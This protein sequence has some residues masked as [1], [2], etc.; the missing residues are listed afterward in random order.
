MSAVKSCPH[1]GCTGTLTPTGYCLA[2]GERVDPHTGL[3]SDAAVR[4]ASDTGPG[5]RPGAGSG[6]ESG[7][8]SGSGSGSESGSESGAA[9]GFDSGT[10]SAPRSGSGSQERESS[11]HWIVE[12]GYTTGPPPRPARIDLPPEHPDPTVLPEITLLDRADSGG[13]G[14]DA[15][16]ALPLPPGTLLAGQY[17]L[18]RPL[19]YG[20]MGEVCLAHDTKVGDRAVAVK[21]LHAELAAD[22]YSLLEGERKELVELNHDG[23]IRVFNYGHH[24][25]V[26]DFLVLQY[27]DGLN[28]EEV[29]ARAHEHP[30]EFGGRR[31]LEFVL[32]Y[33]VRIL[34]ALAYLHAPERGKVYGDLKPPNVMHDGS[35]TKLVDV[36]SVRRA[37]V[38][39][40]T[41]GLYR[42]PSVGEHG[43]SAP[44]DDLF[45][46]GE[47]LRTLCG[48]GATRHDLADLSALDPLN[49]AVADHRGLGLVSLARVLRRATRTARAGRFA[50]ARE[51]DEQLRGVFRELRSLRTG[52]ET[53]EPSPLFLQSAYA[54]DGGLGAAPEVSRWA[55]PPS[56]P[57]HLAP[58]PPEVARRLPV[59]R[60]DPDDDHHGEL[61]RLSDDDPEALLQHTADWRDSPEVHLLRCRLR[62]RAAP[63][64]DG[65][66]LTEAET[67]LAL[68]E[69]AIGPAR[70]PYDWRLDWHRGL[71]ALAR[72]RVAQARGHFDRV[73]GAIPGEYAP[74]LALG[75]CAERLD[76]R[77]EALTFYEA[78][79]LRNPSL[80]SAAFGAVRAR[81]ALGGPD[82]LTAAIA[83][84]DAV[85]Q[86]SRHRTAARTAAVRILVDH[87]GDAAGLGA[88]V[89]A[90]AQLFSAHG[91]T[92]EQSRVRMKAEVWGAAH[93]LLHAGE[94]VRGGLTAAE[95]RAVA[96][97]ADPLLQF[98]ADE[99]ALRT[100]LAR[101]YRG[102]AHQAAR[103][104]PG[105][106]DHDGTGTPLAELLLDRAYAVR[107]FGF[108]HSRFGKDT[109]WLGMKIRNRPPRSPSR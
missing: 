97:H 102:L 74:K 109:P 8:G 91:L 63:R 100:D 53:F 30:E 19:G 9:T 36:G 107:P 62:L 35:T 10:R 11:Q 84:L 16:S 66:P 101:F 5:S 106:D 52:A 43:E 88:A 12:P 49:D 58:D 29:R 104:A 7:V 87:A 14:P 59:P 85:P 81:I 95:L 48:I 21:M 98:P 65:G 70:A 86:H 6:S 2:S 54:L 26:G 15:P 24:T 42:A 34:A 99:R 89:R 3:H 46:L 72:S 103:S 20:G 17:R 13:P 45:S 92:D 22:S 27:V 51:M 56:A 90:L 18:V 60:P 69:D 80:G 31:F 83:A 73:Y 57:R 41:T 77:H 50:T 94:G 38:P 79:R 64:T 39:G 23:F 67:A 32:A 28:L 4:P 96:A 37:G 71:L 33:G 44:Q 40:L 1:P 68:A 47:T 76:R 55:A 105:G 82:A 75:Y 108:R 78:V 93:R 61:S 25:G